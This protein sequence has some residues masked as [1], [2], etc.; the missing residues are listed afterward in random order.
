ME[1]TLD[2]LVPDQAEEGED[3]GDFIDDSEVVT[4]S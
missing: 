2:E 3:D 4:K 1:L